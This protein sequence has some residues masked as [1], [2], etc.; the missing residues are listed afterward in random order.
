MQRVII[1]SVRKNPKPLCPWRVQ[2]AGEGCWAPQCSHH[3]SFGLLWSG[4]EIALSRFSAQA[5]RSHW[6]L[7]PARGQLLKACFC[8]SSP[9]PCFIFIWQLHNRKQ[10]FENIEKENFKGIDSACQSVSAW[11]GDGMK[12]S[13]EGEVS[14]AQFLSVSFF[15]SRPQLG[16]CGG[17]WP[18][19]IYYTQ[20]QS[21]FRQPSLNK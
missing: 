3:V 15:S 17:S 21:A 12:C 8:S 20:S 16:W 11:C 14:A 10:S 18:V 19:K 1:L 5:W 2:T 9:P 13:R 4:R 6:W 7:T